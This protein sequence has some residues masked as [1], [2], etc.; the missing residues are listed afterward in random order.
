MGHL[1]G[2]HAS[3]PSGYMPLLGC[4]HHSWADHDEILLPR[5]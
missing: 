4:I 2:M 1:V 5:P 3:S